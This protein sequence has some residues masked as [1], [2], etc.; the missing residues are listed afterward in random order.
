MSYTE[1]LVS[2]RGEGAAEGQLLPSMLGLDR[3]IRTNPVSFLGVLSNV[4]CGLTFVIEGP[5]IIF[6]NSRL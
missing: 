6:E 2:P 5:L 4:L 1:S 3:G